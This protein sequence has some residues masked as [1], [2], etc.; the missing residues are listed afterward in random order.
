TGPTCFRRVLASD[1]WGRAGVPPG[2][3]VGTALPV[4]AKDGG[5]RGQGSGVQAGLLGAFLGGTLKEVSNNASSSSFIIDDQ[6]G[7]VARQGGGER[8][9]RPLRDTPLKAA[10]AKSSDGTLAD[11][12]LYTTQPIGSTGWRLVLIANK[13]TVLDPVSGTN[14]WLPWLI[15]VI[16]AIALA[17]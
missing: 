11:D 8:T 7:V 15:L 16:G 12:R 4:K 14:R 13:S 9:G 5:T 2:G 6:G 10:I 3:A 1:S 17:A